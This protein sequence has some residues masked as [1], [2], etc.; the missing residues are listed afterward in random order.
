MGLVRG[1][2]HDFHQECLTQL[3]E[4]SAQVETLL[5]VLLRH[6]GLVAG[7]QGLDCLHRA[8]L[9]LLVVLALQPGQEGDHTVSCGLVE[10]WRGMGSLEAGHRGAHDGGGED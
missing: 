3:R 4:H 9:Q 5:Q 6:G 7:A 2:G 8:S 10:I 1:T